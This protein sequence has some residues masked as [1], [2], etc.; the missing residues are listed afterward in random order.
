VHAEEKLNGVIGRSAPFV[1]DD[2]PVK[3][4]VLGSIWC[5][6][7]FFFGVVNVELARFEISIFFEFLIFFFLL[8]KD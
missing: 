5:I 6:L 7:A 4:D 3:N 2:P 8:Q 1:Q